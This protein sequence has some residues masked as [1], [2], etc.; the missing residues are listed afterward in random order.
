[1][2]YP[3]VL[4][5]RYNKYA[6]IDE[7]LNANKD[8][9]M[10]TI[11]VID[12][13]TELNKMFSSNYHLLITFGPNGDKEY[14]N[15]V[16]SI[17]SDRI[18]H[19]WIHY[20][21]LPELNALNRSLSY[22][23]VNNSI[24]PREQTRPIFSI[25]TTCYN[26]FE[27]IIRAYGSLKEQT[28]KDW[29]WVILDDS[30][31]DKHFEF[32]RQTFTNDHR[33]R[34]YRK[35]ANSG[36]IGDVKNEAVSLCRGN[37]VLEFD[38]DDEILPSVL[39]TSSNVFD[40]N[41]E[42]GFIYMDFINIYENGD[43]FSYG[44]GALCRG[45]SG[46]YCQKYKNRW[47]NVYITANVN[48]I[49][50]SHLTC[51]PNHPRI[52]R[53]KVLIDIGNYSEFLHICDDY[54]VLLRTAINTTMVKITELGYVQYM[55]NGNNN[56]SLIRNSEINRIGPSFI[57]PQFYEMYDV[58]KFLQ[59]KDAFEDEKYMRHHTKIWER[60]DYEH[61]Y[62]NKIIN[63]KY[64]FQYCIIGI[65]SLVNHLDFI[66]EQ[67][68]NSRNDF[69]LL[70]NTVTN[71]VLFK[72]LDEHSLDHFK[73]YSLIGNSSQE[74]ENFFNLLYKSCN[75]TL[76]IDENYGSEEDLTQI[77]RKINPV[78]SVPFNTKFEHRYEIINAKKLFIEN[79]L[80]IGIEYGQTFFNVIA[81]NYTGVDPDPKCTSPF[82]QAVTSDAFFS[83][84]KDNTTKYDCIFIDGMHQ[85][86][87]ILRDLN[88]CMNVVEPTGTIFIDDI[89]PLTRGEQLK[90]PH[91]HYYEKGILKYGE[92][93][94]GDVWKVFYYIL[95][96]WEG[97]FE[98]EYFNH[99]NYR[100][101]AILN[102]L[103][104]FRIDDSEETLAL[105][106]SYDYYSDFND[107]TAILQKK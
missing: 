48:N 65:R 76:I 13:K 83:A 40:Q 7:Y 51:C 67:C 28:L 1:M 105:I 61:K 16:N 29:E 64:D 18:R 63:V 75:K 9:I 37:F 31:D 70:D 99:P 2:R 88:N 32:L 62:C 66:R 21:E 19:R 82:I 68:K 81:N 50:L 71:Q 5:F 90:I 69:I 6:A 78:K 4:F 100:G 55:N 38:H 15:D 54:E 56:F 23:L 80:E 27:K 35:S 36:S 42:V 44:D 103:K 91:K 8:K 17:V 95:K 11:N 89:L 39:E 97:H 85:V 72:F 101:V 43:N 87:Y 98:F 93:W 74:L 30:P 73:C 77:K 24:K 41:P 49:T 86:E 34:F 96:T 102:I 92:P 79:Y 107:Y 20:N 52:W 10:A 59:D 22:C 47:V 33:V 57:S 26:S 60:T 106:N 12:N 14:C 25:F 84:L 94:T 58:K 3:I 53:R 45:Y 46:Y 104:P